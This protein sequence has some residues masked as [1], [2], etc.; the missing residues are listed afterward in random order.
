MYGP[1]R[2]LATLAVFQ[3]KKKGNAHGIPQ[4]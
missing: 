2:G 4:S 1:D 3:L